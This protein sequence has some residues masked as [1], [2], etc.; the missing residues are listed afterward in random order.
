M[1][2][3]ESKEQAEKRSKR[4]Q[5]IVGGIL[6]FVML[7]STLGYGFISKEEQNTG[8]TKKIVYN[9]Y[10]F[11]NQ[12]DI[13]TLSLGQYIFG[14]KFN[15]KE[16]DQINSSINFLNNYVGKPLYISSESSEAEVEIYR[17]LDQVVLRRQYAC[18]EGEN[19]TNPEY[20]IKTCADNFIIIQENEK[21][22]ITQIENCVFVKGKKENLTAMTDEFLFKILNV[23]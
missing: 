9:G 3:I 23:E 4:N 14:F 13:W 1:R 11:V 8:S 10:E 5:L 22:N 18:L 7:S 19:C 16:V 12:N 20:P 21:S 2:R 6:I 17:N 15:P